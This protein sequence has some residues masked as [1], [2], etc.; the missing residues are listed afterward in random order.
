[1]GWQDDA[2]YGAASGATYGS[3]FGPWGAAIGAV[4]GGLSGGLRASDN[5]YLKGV[6]VALDPLNLFKRPENRVD[7]AEKMYGGVDPTGQQALAS[8]RAELYGQQGGAFGQHGAMG[9]AQGG[10]DLRAE[11]DQMRRYARGEDSVSAAQLRQGLQQLQSQQQS[12][13]AG[14]SPANSAMAARTAASNAARIGGGL[15]GQQA[16]AGLQERQM[17]QQGLNNMMLAQ[18]QQD[19]Q[20]TLGGQQNAI[21]A[22]QVALGGYGNIENNR[23]QRY[24]TVAGGANKGEQNAGML[25][26]AGGAVGKLF[27]DRR[28]K[29]DMRDGEKDADRLLK[30]LKAVTYKYKDPKHG[31]SD[32]Q[33]G[34]VA[35]DLERAGLKQ[36]VTDTPEGKMVDGARLAAA[37]AAAM[38]GLDKR[39]SKLERKR[40]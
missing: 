22:Q 15:A 14:A 21:N 30:G 20:A 25:G 40:G 39:L 5:K 29:T 1:M 17:A 26:A 16:V 2:Q 24:E 36:A 18:R 19:L 4:G 28:L 3:S 31:G 32:R 23:T 11:A 13:A 38:P 37:L 7:T 12:M 8:Q 6:G 35:Q 10:R 33:L 34:I 27:S 9:Y